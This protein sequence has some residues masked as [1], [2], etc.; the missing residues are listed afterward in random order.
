[1]ATSLKSSLWIS[2]CLIGTNAIKGD[3]DAAITL[4][5]S[6]LKS[7]KNSLEAKN[8]IKNTQKVRIIKIHSAIMN[9]LQIK[10][11]NE[12]TNPQENSAVSVEL[13]I[14]IN[15]MNKTGEV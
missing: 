10:F 13:A 2:K 8:V 15:K 11:G 12:P 4:K 5:H 1:M 14:E 3:N 6:K 9:K 7:V